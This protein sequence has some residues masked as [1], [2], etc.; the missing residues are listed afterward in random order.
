MKH[1]RITKTF[2]CI[3]SIPRGT[4]IGASHQPANVTSDASVKGTNLVEEGKK[5]KKKADRSNV[6]Y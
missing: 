3:A 5:K 6:T 1:N 2:P 4:G